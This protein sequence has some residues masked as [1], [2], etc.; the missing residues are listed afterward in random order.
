[1]AYY[2]EGIFGDIRTAYAVVHGLYLPEIFRRGFSCNQPEE[3][4]VVRMCWPVSGRGCIFFLAAAYGY[5]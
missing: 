4:S 3:K 5:R 1:M 2:Q